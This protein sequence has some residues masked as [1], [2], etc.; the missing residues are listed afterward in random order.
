[1]RRRFALVLAR[2]YILNLATCRLT[3]DKRK[4]VEEEIAKLQADL[5]MKLK[6]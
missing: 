1:M 3:Q 2:V 4:K 5:D 6:V